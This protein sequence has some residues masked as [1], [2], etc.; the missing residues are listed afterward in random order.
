MGRKEN[1]E[2][3]NY[4]KGKKFVRKERDRREKFGQI[5]GASF[6]QPPSPPLFTTSL[7]RDLAV[8]F[9]TNP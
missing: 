7:S 3:A 6:S 4:V 1:A 9:K 5:L 2:W 8:H